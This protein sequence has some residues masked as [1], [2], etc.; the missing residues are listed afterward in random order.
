[1]KKILLIGAGRSASSLIRY[2]Q[3]KAQSEDWLITIADI[4]VELAQQKAKGHERSKAI[5]F[6]AEDIEL[7][8]QLISESDLVISMLPARF[9]NIIAE[10]CIDLK[11]NIITPSYASPEMYA[12]DEKAKEAGVLLMNELGVDPGIDHMSAMKLIHE[13]R[14]KGGVMTGFESFTGG[15]LAPESE[16][17]N[18]W[19]YKFTWNPRNV[20]LAG[21]GGAVKFIQENTYK[22]IPYHKLFRRTEYIDIPGHGKFEG[23]AN[24]DSLKYRSI[25]G[26][27][28][29]KTIFRGTLRRTGF[30]KAWDVFVQL[31]ATDDSYEIKNC[32]TMTHRQFF[33][34]FLAYNPHDSVE[35][36]LMHY[37]KID[38]DSR[39]MERLEWIGM[40]DDEVIGLDS[41]TPAQLL[42]HI[43]KKK[44]KLEEDDKDMIVMWHKFTYDLGGKS[45]E[46]H[47]SMVS[48]GEDQV[49]TAMS[50]TVGLPLGIAARH[51]LNGNIKLTGVQL[52]MV[53][54][55]YNPILEELEEYGIQFEDR[56]VE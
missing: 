34:L 46:L 50:N 56:E 47:S 49:F 42:E 29:V 22:Y 40:F 38:Q 32:S 5:A 26:L 39:V 16:K 12:L 1:M 14:E 4:D 33:N 27:E 13:I 2:L 35:L 36:K 18:P 52:P 48:V 9:H 37:M 3:D 8:K 25:Y 7:R 15:L 43:L 19:K 20:V 23:Y 17:D 11:K 24:R 53:P 10:D 28:D 30:S 41:G 55:I 21:Q 54:E 44:W 45:H 51:V 6:K 31:G